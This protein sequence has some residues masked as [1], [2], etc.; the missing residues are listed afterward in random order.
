MIDDFGFYLEDRAPTFSY[1]NKLGFVFKPYKLFNKKSDDNR[2][3]NPLLENVKISDN[4][5][6]ILME[7]KELP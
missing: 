6:L 4:P 3:L 5:V 2:K 1:K 7:L